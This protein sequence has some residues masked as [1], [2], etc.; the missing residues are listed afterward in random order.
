MV[1]SAVRARVKADAKVPSSPSA[2]QAA[3]RAEVFTSVARRAWAF[4][5]H[6]GAR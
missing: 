1:S 4:R 5:S 2:P 3:I 6:S